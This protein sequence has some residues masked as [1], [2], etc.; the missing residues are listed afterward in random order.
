MRIPAAAGPGWRKRAIFP[1][2]LLSA[3]L[4]LPGLHRS[5][6]ATRR[7]SIRRSRRPAEWEPH[8]DGF[9]DDQ[10]R[11]GRRKGLLTV[12]AVFGLA[13]IGTAGAFGYRT[14]VRSSGSSAPPPVIRAS[15]EPSKVAPPVAR[16]RRVREQVQL[17]S[18]RRRRQG[19]AGGRASRRKANGPDEGRAA[20]CG[21]ATPGRS[22]RPAGC[23]TGESPRI[24]PRRRPQ[25]PPQRIRRAPSASRGVCAPFR[26]VP[27]RAA[28]LQPR[29]RRRAPDETQNAALAPQQRAPPREESSGPSFRGQ[30]A[31][32]PAR[33]RPTT[34]WHC[35][36]RTV[37]CR[38]PSQPRAAAGA[39]PPPGPDC[40]GGLLRGY[41]R[42]L[43]G[44][45][46]V[47]KKRGQRGE[48]YR[49]I[50]SKYPRVLGS[51]PHT[52]RRADLGA[53]GVYY[54]AMVGPFAA[55]KRRCRFAA[56]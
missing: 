10:P 48:A 35:P 22:R 43:S 39:S 40:F 33:L 4:G 46:V 3:R 31:A 5:G 49:G 44:A 34:R 2:G 50:Q 24:L 11:S 55:A 36:R 29:R 26:S 42:Q 8:A 13:V 20:A 18:L 41:R 51:H 9:Y 7:R 21:G 56:A 6:P 54:R 37:L 53:K 12:V 38:P 1:I 52:V 45:G 17:R 30:C 14:M 27:N 16:A 47:A 15:V 32:V 19:R 23:V 28:T 25:P